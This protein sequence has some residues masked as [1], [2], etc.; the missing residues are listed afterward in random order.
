MQLKDERKSRAESSPSLN[1]LWRGPYAGRTAEHYFWCLRIS[2]YKCRNSIKSHTIERSRSI[3]IN[4]SMSASDSHLTSFF[5]TQSVVIMKLAILFSAIV[6]A[7][8]FAPNSVSISR[9]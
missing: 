5:S 6:G 2:S 4:S 9:L 7:S 8:A 3:F 1:L